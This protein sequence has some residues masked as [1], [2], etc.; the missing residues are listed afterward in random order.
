MGQ[1][2]EAVVL[3]IEPANAKFCLGIKQLK[4]NPWKDV[5]TR[6]SIGTIVEAKV[7]RIA[8]FGIFVE[9][10]EGIEGLIHISELSAERVEDP[11]TI[12]KEGDMVKAV[13]ISLDAEMQKISLSIKT[14]EGMEESQIL[15]D[16][17]EEAKP[18]K[19]AEKLKGFFGGGKSTE[20]KTTAQEEEAP[21]NSDN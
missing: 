15:K 13:V 8:D 17:T 6:F 16:K 21:S 2:I 14:A 5:E 11:S 18:V 3:A 12:A 7:L 9:L 19:L 1:N 10:K 4:E 20:E